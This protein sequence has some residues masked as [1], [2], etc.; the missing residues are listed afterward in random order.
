MRI[1]R[2]DSYDFFPRSRGGAPSHL[3]SLVVAF[4]AALLASSSLATP[5]EDI[6]R[7][8][9]VNGVSDISQTRPKQ[10]LKAFTAITIRT[11]PRELPGYVVAAV[12][13]R[14]DL[15]PKIT[16]VA[17]KAAVK[18]WESKQGALLGLID[19]IIRAA[20]TADPSAAISIVQAG[21]EASPALRHCVMTA[22]VAAAPNQQTAIRFA[23]ESHFAS[24]ALLSLSGIDE[25]VFPAGSVTLNPASVNSPEQPPSR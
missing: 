12:N 7:A 20:I 11:Q 17:I 19:Q 24:L 18:G 22:A 16:A 5:T 2:Q 9:A 10:F 23:A 8:V 21:V 15:S 4:S 6:E 25:A 3:L 13:L 1:F 14:R